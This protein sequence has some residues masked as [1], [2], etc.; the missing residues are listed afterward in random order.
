MLVCRESQFAYNGKLLVGGCGRS[1]GGGHGDNRRKCV[2]YKS[3]RF[4]L[5]RCRSVGG[6]REGVQLA[7][8]NEHN[9]LISW[10]DH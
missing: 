9:P 1:V 4:D 3:I 10:H 5:R 6:E 7:R 2:S 8:D